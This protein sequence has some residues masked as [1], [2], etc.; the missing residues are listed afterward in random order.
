M[1]E[2]LFDAE[3][4]PMVR[5]MAERTRE[6]ETADGP[7]IRAMVWQ[8]LVRL[9]ATRLR[10]P[11]ASG[12]RSASQE[13]LVSAAEE[14]G[15][16][17]CQGPLLDTLTAVELLLAPGDDRLLDEVCGGAGVALAVRAD[18]AASPSEP[19]EMVVAE[20]SGAGEITAERCFVG[21]ASEVDH[22]VVAGRAAGDTRVALVSRAHPSVTLRRHQELGRGELWRVRCQATPV[23]AWL[24]GADEWAGVVAGARSRQAGY[25]VGLSQSALDLAVA[26]ATRRRQFG[27]P[28]GRFQSLAF[29]LSELVA[30]TDAARLLT[31]AAAAQADRGEDARLTAAQC[32]ATAA[33]LARVV[34]AAALQVH[35]AVGMTDDSDAQL[36]YCRAVIEALWWGTPTQ[37]R[38]EAAP[39]L[40]A[41][42]S[43]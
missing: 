6:G 18:G 3:L 13:D 7:Q 1:F 29:R 38:A 16:A 27:Q 5:R 32:L 30:R 10:L 31:R 40:R 37:L 28:I 15:A 25:L 20:G 33:D 26:H 4:A 22:L 43:A 14:L 12:G 35:G 34:T 9:G 23:L 19:G 8:A 39:L 11:A 2:D 17:L 24:G 42:L 36:C 41:Q 21:Y